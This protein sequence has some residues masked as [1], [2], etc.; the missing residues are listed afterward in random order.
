MPVREPV[1]LEYTKRSQVSYPSHVQ[2]AK[3][4]VNITGPIEAYKLHRL[5]Y[6]SLFNMGADTDGYFITSDESQGIIASFPLMCKIGFN[7]NKTIRLGD[8]D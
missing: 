7:M 1:C 3:E 2:V 5:V 4:L 6:M 8:L